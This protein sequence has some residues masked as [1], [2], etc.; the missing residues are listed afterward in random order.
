MRRTSVLDV[1]VPLVLAGTITYSLLQISY[2]SL[3]PF[4]W[5]VALP[6][7][8]LAIAELV[9]ARRVRAAV[10]HRP[11]AKPV[12]ALAIARAVALAKASSLV[13]AGVIG[14]GS[15]LILK[16]IPDAPRVKAASA[17][18]RVGVLVV[19]ASVALTI[20]GLLLERAAIDPAQSER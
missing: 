2:E 20:A 14:A 9:I 8:A 7:A 6:M 13:G 15:G 17:D 11:G 4:G 3:P 5:Y 18:L 12:T 1:V 16:V 10:R 19:L